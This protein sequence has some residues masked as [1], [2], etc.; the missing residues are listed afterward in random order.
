MCVSGWLR[1]SPKESHSPAVKKQR[2]NNSRVKRENIRLER[3]GRK[4]KLIKHLN[5]LISL[6]Q[7]GLFFWANL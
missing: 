7:F 1:T 4:E 2:P 5:K 6:L 3:I